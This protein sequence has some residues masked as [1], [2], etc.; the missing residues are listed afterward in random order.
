MPSL[1]IL[2][3]LNATSCLVFGVLFL[4]ASRMTAGF[5]GSAPVWLVAALGA[6]LLVNGVHLILASRRASPRRIEIFYFVTG[7]MAWVIATLALIISGTFVTTV[8]GVAVAA[9]VAMCVGTLGT[10][11]YMAVRQ[12]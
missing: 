5:L 7:D 9:V 8:Q 3:R 4:F 6:L 11:Q 10:L 12:Q 2:L 1:K